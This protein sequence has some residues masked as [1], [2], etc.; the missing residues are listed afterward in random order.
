MR[1]HLAGKFDPH[2]NQARSMVLSTHACLISPTLFHSYYASFFLLQH[3]CP[4]VFG[5]SMSLYT[6]SRSASVTA[7]A[8]TSVK[9]DRDGNAIASVHAAEALASV[10]CC[11]FV[12]TGVIALI[13][14][15]GGKA[16]NPTSLLDATTTKSK[17]TAAQHQDAWRQ[18]VDG[19]LA[20]LERCGV[21]PKDQLTQAALALVL[22]SKP[23]W[24]AADLATSSS[25]MEQD[26]NATELSSR[27]E[28]IARTFGGLFEDDSDNTKGQRVAAATAVSD[29]KP[30]KQ[31]LSSASSSAGGV[32]AMVVASLQA[33][34]SDGR[35]PPLARLALL[36]G[37]AHGVDLAVL[38]Q[39]PLR[40]GE[41]EGS[42]LLCGCLFRAVAEKC[43]DANTLVQVYAFQ[44]GVFV[45]VRTTLAHTLYHH[46]LLL[47]C[48]IVI[49]HLKN[50]SSLK[51][52]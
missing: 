38:L 47:T 18:L 29:A 36:R 6:L 2:L 35:L 33:R 24:A 17:A 50:R 7:A 15:R 41:G 9:R 48:F 14:A 10:E 11:G 32:G 8:P 20:L 19:C 42:G 43:S 13:S 30:S 46:R 3:A 39:P 23:L 4:R 37:I 16:W 28:A 45:N 34:C 27:A 26:D 31:L 44:V 40:A 52:H 12:L 49:A 5:S 51:V 22:L 25:S 1:L 21:V